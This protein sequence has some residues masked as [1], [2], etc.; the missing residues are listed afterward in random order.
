MWGA[1]KILIGAFNVCR[2]ANTKP[3]TEVV[4]D[5]SMGKIPRFGDVSLHITAAAQTTTR[6]KSNTN[7]W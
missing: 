2:V 1:V 4:V 3:G 7:Y 6:T 5:V